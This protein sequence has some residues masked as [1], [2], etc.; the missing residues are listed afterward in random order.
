MGV[1]VRSP[2][3]IIISMIKLLSIKLY[4][5]VFNKNQIL[6]THTLIDFRM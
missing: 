2:W 5:Y 1:S 4:A 6:K 3:F